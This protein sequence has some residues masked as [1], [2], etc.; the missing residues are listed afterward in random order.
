MRRLHYLELVFY[1]AWCDLASEAS[2]AYVGFLWWIL[3]PLF[4]MA[5]FYIAFGIGLKAGGT[6]KVLFLLSG[7]VPWKW[8]SSSVQ[9]GSLAIQNN[10]GLIQQVYLPKYIL[11]WIVV[12][13][14][15]AKFLI[16]LALLLLLAV[17]LGHGP[18]LQW[19]A[20]PVLVLVE[21][22][23]IAALTALT[24][25]LVPLLPD[26][27]LIVDNGLMVLMFLSGIF[28]EVSSVPPKVQAVLRANPIV[29]VI[30]G[31]RSV[32]VDRTWPDW[33]GLVAVGIAAGAVYALAYWVLRRFDREY[34]KHM[35]G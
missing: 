9:N 34:P 12:I 30:E 27:R 2:R 21:F 23:L 32:L 22:L 8:F 29:P 25:S 7:L 13:T 19:L 6:E 24:A 5:A 3:E 1:K 10:S 31:Y 33:S 11:P 26:L 16:I 18:N 20:L 15:S 17:F 14:N 35:I 4:Y 28:Y